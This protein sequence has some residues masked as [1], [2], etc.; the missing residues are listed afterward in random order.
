MRYHHYRQ[1]VHWV[2]TTAN[3]LLASYPGLETP[4]LGLRDSAARGFVAANRL[5]TRR[6]HVA[7]T[8]PYRLYWVDPAT[9]TDSISWQELTSDWGS[10]IPDPFTV[11]NYHF[12]GRVLDGEWDSDRRPFVESVIYRSF[13]NH[14]E[15]GRPWPQTDLYA[16][17]ADVIES[18]GSPWGCES[19]SALDERC[20]EID[21]LFETVGRDGYRTQQE[22]ATQHNQPLVAA[23]TNRYAQ[24]VDGEI[25]LV[26]GRDG[27]LLFYD[28]RNRLAIAKLAGIESIPVVILARHSQ[29][30]AVRDAVASGETPL[31][32]VD[33]VLRSHPD[34]VDLPPE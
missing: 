8:D 19:L 27:E 29:W 28:G 10:V 21:R 12:A 5:R 1:F 25:A 20:R 7:P 14:F 33:D 2:R 31:E 13:R 18:G 30:Q 6:R 9:I 32:S 16:Q 3:D 23:R 11:P 15:H 24:T 17:S 4:L 22:I 26:V 34:L